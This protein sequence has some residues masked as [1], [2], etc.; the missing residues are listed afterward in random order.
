MVV[1]VFNA[2]CTPLGALWRSWQGLSSHP[3]AS[4][5]VL[6]S[7]P[8]LVS[9]ASGVG[10]ARWGQGTPEPGWGRGA[11]GVT[12]E[13]GSA[14][15]TQANR[16]SLASIA[17]TR[18]LGLPASAASRAEAETLVPVLGGR[19]GTAAVTAGENPT[20]VPGA[21]S[22]AVSQALFPQAVRGRDEEPP[23]GVLSGD[24]ALCEVP[25]CGPTA[26]VQAGL[27]GAA[28]VALRAPLPGLPALQLLHQQRR[29]AGLPLR[30]HLLAGGSRHSLVRCGV[31]GAGDCAD[32][33]HRGHCLHLPA[34]PHPADLPA[35]LDLLASCL[36]PLEPA[37]DP[38]PL[39]HGHHHP[40]RAPP[41]GQEQ[42]CG[43]LHLQEMHLPQACPRAPLQHLQ[44]T[45][46][47]TPPPTFSFRQ[48]AFHK[49]IVYLW[50][51][52]SSVALALGALTLWHAALITRGETSIER[53]IN[54]KERQR[55][56]KKGRVFRNPYSYG[57]WANWKVFLGVDTHRHWLTR[58]LLPSTHLPHGTGL[59]WDHPPCVTEPHTPLLAI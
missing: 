28:A 42:H 35:R 18:G 9:S 33:L 38:L 55:L 17:A 49:S 45:Y 59:S 36:R 25:A 37:H 12:G 31:C 6:P 51:L 5:A 23:A 39:L 16:R 44:Q 54:K 3:G 46:Y 20:P 21:P 52:C 8:S 56:Q 13:L 32:K 53:H 19:D 11:A 27:A 48:R 34:A 40:A 29:G 14:Y 10:K 15:P 22:R 2:T 24:A 26:Q 43:R 57:T 7:A 47:Q 58:V 30:A 4:P 50:V 1:W 41:A